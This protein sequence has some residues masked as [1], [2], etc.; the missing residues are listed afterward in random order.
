MVSRS[1]RRAN[2]CLIVGL[3]AAFAL[4]AAGSGQACTTAVV[5]G[6]ATANGRPLLWKNRDAENKQNQV[7]YDDTGRYPF[8]GVVNSGDP[9]GFE[10]WAGVNAR[11]FA[12]MNSVSYNLAT[13]DSTAEGQLMRLALQS[14]AT[15]EEFQALL[16]K[17][18]GAAT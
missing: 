16:E 1:T 7:V 15:I 10:V 18:N 11:G 8:V 14:C 2:R 3:A 13:T 6:S 4:A 5:A 12:I 9:A 17:T